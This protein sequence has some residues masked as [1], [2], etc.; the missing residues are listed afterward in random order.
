M[1]GAQRGTDLHSLRELRPER[2]RVSNSAILG[3]GADLGGPA[4]LCQ[5]QNASRS[6]YTGFVQ[7]VV[8]SE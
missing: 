6:N 5:R 8:A 1:D 2:K 7:I 4:L 3:I